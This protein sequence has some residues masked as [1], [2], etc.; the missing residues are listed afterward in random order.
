MNT[1]IIGAGLIGRKRAEALPKEI[2][3][4]TI[5]DIDE[6]RAKDF[7]DDF[8]CQIKTDWRDVVKDPKIQALII[9]TINKFLS[10]IAT[11]AILQGKHVLVEKPGARNLKELEK[12]ANAHK[13][14]S[15]IMFGF[16]HRYHPAIIMAKKIIDSKKYGKVL[17][18][19]AKYG[20]G[21]R[22]GY[23]KEWRFNKDL[24]GGGELLDQGTHLIDLVNHFCGE[25]PQ[26]IGLTASLFWKSKLEDSAFFI[27]KRRGGPIA[28][29]SATCVEWK[30][31][32]CFEIM[33]KTAKIQ[34]DG[35]GGSYGRE[36]L[37]LYKMKPEMGPPD[38]EEFLFDEKDNS[39]RDETKEFFN[40]IKKKDYNNQAISDTEYVLKVV[41]KLYK[42]SFSLNKDNK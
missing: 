8:K 38:V 36:K 23:E 12:V 30:N 40:R 19:R 10:P 37:T 33:L 24:A 11:E 29:L 4:S 9:S 34:I 16:N 7:T 41:A 18:I 5:C 26:V 6:K 1:A 15:V 28:H 25:F 13:K 27:L 42:Q 32:F 31:L 20:H 21:G 35:L 2:T 22:L 39:W 17:F 14:K 3:L